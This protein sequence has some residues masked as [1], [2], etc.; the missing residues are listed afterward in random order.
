[1]TR[2]KQ[3]FRK[4]GLFLITFFICFLLGSNA[5][6]QKVS[7]ISVDGN[8]RVSEGTIRSYL[9]LEIGDDIS[10][11]VLDSAIDRL[12]ATSLFS[13]VDITNVDGNI[14]I[15][16]IE[17]PIINRITVEGNDV[18]D[19]DILIAQLGIQPRRVYTKKVALDGMQKLIEIYQ[20]SGRY[21]ASVE[22]VIIELENN[23]VDLVF[24]VDEGPLIKIKSIQFDGNVRYSDR[25]LKQVIASREKRWWAFLTASDKYDE[26][27]L[28]YDIRLLRQFYQ[29]RGYAD[30]DIKRARGG[31]LPDRSGF[32]ISFILDEGPIYQFKKI[33]VLSEI[34]G[35]EKDVIFPAITF[36][37]GDRYDIRK[38]EESLLAVTNKLGDLGYAFVNVTPD[39]TTNPGNKTLDVQIK[40]DQARK[41]YVERI[42][43]IDNSRTADFVIRR[44]MQLVEGDAYNQVKLQKS[45]RNIRNLG[46]FSDVSVRSQQGSSADQSVIEVDVEE[47]STGSLSVGVGY[48]SIDK[49]SVSIGIDEKN[50]LGTGRAV[51]FGAKVSS[52][53]SDFNLS[54][55]EPYFLNR[56]LSASA[57]ILQNKIKGTSATI[58]K[59]G[60]G[61]GLG[62]K[63]ANDIYHRLGYKL[64]ESKTDQTA[65]SSSSSTGEN[66]KKLISSAIS[67][68]LGI[69]KRDNRFDPSNGYF[70]EISETYSGIG[71]DVNYLQTVLRGAYYKPISFERFVLGARIETGQ[72][73]G[74]GD[75]VTQSNRFLLGGNKVRGF[76][77]SGIGPRDSTSDGAVGGNQYYAGSFDIISGAGLNP[78]L[79]MRWTFFADY[80]SAWGTDFPTGVDGADDNSMRQ[81][82]G[83]GIL[84]DTAIG[85][86]SFYWADPISKQPYDKLRDFQ[87]TIGT[88]L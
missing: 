55:T 31:L 45:I 17:N 79:G 81:S 13:D 18:L 38:L 25:R 15:R 71:G 16:V 10:T 53:K 24:E 4:S 82:V 30:I 21:G 48:S 62:F 35:V 59:R 26:N 33:D 63:A 80:G 8:Q 41:N 83:F 12:F 78:D 65:S 64:V 32:A 84:W 9:P 22:P 11:A 29:A 54:L 19:K 14:R 39:V 36:E 60:I 70:A 5:F 47:Q 88:R 40:I 2:L 57:N 28:N 46:F 58:E 27:R 56:N 85:P 86:L 20:L 42:E 44:E 3:L 76:D 68:R 77:G 66:G 61:F 73:T 6:A 51:G 23:R 49:S 43:I 37:T 72:V 52:S 34:E 87:F 50:F 69:E 7:G 74:L 75:D 67:Y 1:M